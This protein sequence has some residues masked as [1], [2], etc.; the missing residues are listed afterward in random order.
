[1]K[2]FCIFQLNYSPRYLKNSKIIWK[3]GIGSLSS[4][5]AKTQM[6]EDRLTSV[7]DINN[8]LIHPQTILA[9]GHERNRCF[10]C[11][12]STEQKKHV[13]LV[14]FIFFNASPNGKAPTI[15]LQKNTSTSTIN[16]ENTNLSR[17]H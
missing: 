16:R 1:M 15:T 11:S 2:A 9:I 6:K 14:M 13:P 5:C 4:I 12:N 8:K 10:L 7:E 3:R 17:S